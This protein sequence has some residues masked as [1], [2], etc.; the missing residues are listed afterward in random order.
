M[1]GIIGMSGVGGGNSYGEI[2]NFQIDEVGKSCFFVSYDVRDAETNC[3]HNLVLNG[4]ELGAD[5]KVG[6]GHFELTV[7]NLEPETE[8]GVQIKINNEGYEL[9][10]KT[11]AVKTEKYPIY[12]VIIDETDPNPSTRCTYTNDSVNISVA[13]HTSYGGWESIYPFNSTRPC[14]L[15]NGKVIKYINPNDYT[16][17]E[18][19]TE[20]TYDVDVMIEVPR[21]YWNTERID[22][23]HI[24]I[25]ISQ[26]R[27]NNY[28]DCLAHTSG[29]YEC[30]NIY[31]GAYEGSLID[32][33]M[34]SVSGQIPSKVTFIEGEESCARNGEG[35][36]QYNYSSDLATQILY[37]IAYKNT[38][39]QS[40][41]GH[42]NTF[43]IKNTGSC[44]TKGMVYGKKLEYIRDEN[45]QIIDD[46]GADK[47]S[48][49]FL[50]IENLYGN[51]ATWLSGLCTDDYGNW[52][53]NMKNDLFKPYGINKNCIK[54]KNVIT[55]KND[56]NSNPNRIA[57]IFGFRDTLF[58][59]SG[60]LKTSEI[61]VSGYY[62]DTTTIETNSVAMKG[63]NNK[64]YL[65]N[66]N[67]IGIFNLNLNTKKDMKIKANSRLVYIPPSPESKVFG[68]RVNETVRFSEQAVTLIED[69]TN[70]EQPQ[71]IEHTRII[72]EAIEVPIEDIPTTIPELN[73]GIIEESININK[74]IPKTLEELNE[75]IVEV[76]KKGDILV[77]EDTPMTIPELE[78][79]KPKTKIEYVDRVEHYYTMNNGDYEWIYPYSLIRPVALKDGKIVEYID[80]EDFT[81]YVNGNSITDDI[82]VMI[83]F[84]KLYI[85]VEKVNFEEYE[86]KISNRKIN[87]KYIC[88]AHTVGTKEVNSIYIGAYEASQDATGKI[89]SQ[90]GKKPITNMTLTNFR[91]KCQERG[92]G[93]NSFNYYSTLLLEALHLVMYPY[94][95]G[96]WIKGIG[97]GNVGNKA[98]LNTG[99]LDKYGMTYGYTNDK[100]KAMKFLGIENL[101]GNTA[102]LI[103][104][105]YASNSNG[106]N[107]IYLSKN[108]IFNDDGNS[109]EKFD[110]IAFSN[111]EEWILKVH[112][113]SKLGFIAKEFANMDTYNSDR[114]VYY[115]TLYSY[116]T[117]IKAGSSFTYGGS[118]KDLKMV[119]NLNIEI[120]TTGVFCLKNE[121]TSETVGG[122]LIYIPQE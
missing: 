87:D 107:S 41:L 26:W 29:D 61:G 59:P 62:C 103:D 57:N 91:T 77:T 46:N 122:R 83:E 78:G 67:N 2:I 52:I 23:N 115:T 90:S 94:P 13:T 39:S 76:D 24:R 55:S 42:G 102:T 88:P 99:Q 113:D 11:L 16:K 69:S 49:K 85:C 5:G 82:D 21:F 51:T 65:G 15:K 95:H 104:G 118:Y 32:K 109:Y 33:K 38:D 89:R 7:A 50:G 92:K 35:Y 117:N 30:D 28:W 111:G 100:N 25:D 75:G 18:D 97:Y 58:L 119:T 4:K 98:L 64:I 93:Y 80:K 45:N 10:S 17:Y 108:D 73:D 116:A 81:K 37:L 71:R 84:P 110:N 12:S 60:T 34:R 31:I 112:A 72:K 106:V 63:D 44:D 120:P 86:V 56:C 68:V 9:Y 66:N 1:A 14:G 101:W 20:V 36:H 3:I 19:G 22:N 27:Y 105:I 43:D 6:N 114:S 8:Y 96:H 121:I 70:I 40:V 79:D 47:E 48:I 53:I 74:D 54:V